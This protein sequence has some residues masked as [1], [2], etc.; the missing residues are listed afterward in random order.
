MVS[1]SAYVLTVEEDY[2]ISSVEFV[3][4]VVE[5]FYPVGVYQP[6]PL[7]MGPTFVHNAD[8]FIGVIP[9]KVCKGS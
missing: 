6:T 5:M 3:A 4:D 2:K 9:L 1:H 8:V 7:V